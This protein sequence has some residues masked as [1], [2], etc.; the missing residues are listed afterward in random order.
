MLSLPLQLCIPK[1]GSVN[2]A[3]LARNDF[4]AH[5]LQPEERPGHFATANGKVRPDFGALPGPA[6]CVLIAA[7]LL[8]RW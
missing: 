1:T 6:R 7:P 5:I 8:L 2:A 4:E 3:T